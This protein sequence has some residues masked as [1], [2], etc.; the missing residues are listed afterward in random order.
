MPDLLQYCCICDSPTGRTFENGHFTS[1]GYALCETCD[2]WVNK[3]KEM[4]EECNILIDRVI[5]LEDEKRELEKQLER[6]E[7]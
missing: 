1:A 5:T 6:D 2:A 3:I 4:N 7:R